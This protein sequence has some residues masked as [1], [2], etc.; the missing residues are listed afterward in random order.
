MIDT[1][2]F[3][4]WDYAD[5]RMILMESFGLEMT[6]CPGCIETFKSKVDEM[7]RAQYYEDMERDAEGYR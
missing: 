4:D 6:A 1:S 3:L 2:N 5:G 7:R